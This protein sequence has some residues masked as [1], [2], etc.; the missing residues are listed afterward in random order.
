[1]KQAN[2]HDKQFA[3]QELSGTLAIPR[4]C[5]KLYTLCNKPETN[6]ARSVAMEIHGVQSEIRQTWIDFHSP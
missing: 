3:A 4:H 5:A 6:V 1:M 2:K